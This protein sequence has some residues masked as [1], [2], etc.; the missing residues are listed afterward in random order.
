MKNTVLLSLI[1]CMVLLVIT[2]CEDKVEITRKYT[3]ME[4]VYMSK[5]EIRSSV[6]FESPQPIHSTGKI[7]YYQNHIFINSPGEGIHII[8]NQD[9]ENPKK[10]SFIN[11]PG[12]YDMAARQ[13]FLYAD[14][15]MDLVV[16]DISDINNIQIV[17]RVE[18]FFLDF[19]TNVVIDPEKGIIVD[20]TPKEEIEVRKGDEYYPGGYR[21]YFFL[22]DYAKATN[23][24]IAVAE[25]VSM[26][27]VPTGI[28]GS[29]ATFT[30]SKDHLYII[31]Q[32]QL[33]VLDLQ[34]ADDP[35]EIF[36][37]MLGGGIETIF[38]YEDYLYVGSQ[39]GLYII[40]NTSPASPVFL[41][42][43][44]HIRSCDPV[45][46]QGNKAYVT[47]RSG[48]ACGTNAR[49]VLDVIDIKD[50]QNPQL[51]ATHNMEHPYGLGIDGDALFVCEGSSGLKFFD[52]SDDQDISDNMLAHISSIDAYDVIPFQGLL[53]LIGND[54]FYQ[55]DYRDPNNLEFLSKLEIEPNTVAE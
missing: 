40:D 36:Q 32:Q 43:Y 53:F 42:I 29:L 14:N 4:P 49:D 5:S 38:P 37:L 26:S 24:S 17:G 18:D 45:V 46:V 22:A 33:H 8:N 21:D 3:V 27:Q 7:Y 35:E 13:G 11:I 44:N 54:G 15:Y 19:N 16:F 23:N 41:S 6:D 25:G 34:E 12:N 31:D 1:C 55:Y 39:N 28:G 9:P 50:K 30:I 20:Y 48:T 47:L 10:V 51:I 2:S 52:A